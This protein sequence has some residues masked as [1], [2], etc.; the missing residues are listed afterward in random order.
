MVDKFV[1]KD[2]MMQR[3]PGTYWVAKRYVHATDYEDL[4]AAVLP[5][6]GAL[7]DHCEACEGAGEI[8]FND[9]TVER[10]MHCKP[11]WDLIQSL[12]DPKP[13]PRPEEPVDDDIAF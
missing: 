11:V 1:L 7:T 12:Q 4:V 8:I 5:H 3:D 9:G 2:R 10:C 6:L 13:S